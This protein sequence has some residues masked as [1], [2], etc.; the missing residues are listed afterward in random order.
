MQNSIVLDRRANRFNNRAV[1]LDSREAAHSP[2][3]GLCPKPDFNREGNP[4]ELI[5]R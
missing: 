2:G 1:V 4:R 5:L 3:S